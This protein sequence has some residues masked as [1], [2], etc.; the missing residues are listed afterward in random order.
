MKV[1]KSVKMDGEMFLIYIEEIIKVDLDESKAANGRSQFGQGCLMMDRVASHL[2]DHVSLELEALQIDTVPILAGQTSCTQPI[3]V[4][5][6]GQSKFQFKSLHGRE[7]KNI[8]E[9]TTG[10]NRKKLP[11]E[12]LVRMVV[13]SLKIHSKESIMRS[14]NACGLCHPDDNLIPSEFICKYIFKGIN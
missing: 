5:I 14:F 7:M 12:T 8:A 2:V 11:Y 9:F 4:V 1:S 3:D 6:N 10:G 13:D